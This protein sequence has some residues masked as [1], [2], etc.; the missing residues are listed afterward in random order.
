MRAIEVYREIVPHL[1]RLAREQKRNVVIKLH[2]F[3]SK[4]QRSS[5][6]RQL[7]GRDDRKFVTVMDGPLTPELLSRAWFGLTVESTTV[8]DC[9]RN[10]VPCFLCGWLSLSPFEY[11]RQYARFGV[12]DVLQTPEEIALIP[13]RLEQIANRPPNPLDLCPTPSPETFR[14][15]LTARSEAIGLRTVS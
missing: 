13:Q 3:E 8:V 15:W 11:A 7:L 14:H 12:G 9:L 5:F 1:C 4:R 10:S 2:P 6:L